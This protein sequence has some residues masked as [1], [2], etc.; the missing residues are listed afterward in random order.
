AETYDGSMVRLF[1]NGAQVA[2]KAETGALAT[3]SNPLQIGGDSIYGQR[4]SGLIDE[5]RVY[6]V[7][8]SAAQIQTDMTTPIATASGTTYNNTTGLLPN[9]SYSYRVR[10]TDAA[11]NLG[12]YSNT[13]TASTPVDS[14]P[15][16][17]PGT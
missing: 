10:A 5:V 2:G 13:F 12:P 3:S 1:V 16:S 6:N 4:F 7:A 9:T 14:T 11:G 8:L 15:P 17:I